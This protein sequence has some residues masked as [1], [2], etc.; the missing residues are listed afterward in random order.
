MERKYIISA[1]NNKTTNILK[2]HLELTGIDHPEWIVVIWG[3]AYSSWWYK[4]VMPNQGGDVKPS[5][6]IP[7]AIMC[8]I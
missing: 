6:Q 4:V 3:D 5:F 1:K 2:M 8:K 7:I